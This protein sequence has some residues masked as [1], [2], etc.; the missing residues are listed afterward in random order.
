MEERGPHFLLPLGSRRSLL[1]GEVCTWVSWLFLVLSLVLLVG[2]L[3]VFPAV[4]GIKWRG[5]SG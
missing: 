2:W 3:S 1:W 5:G 4:G